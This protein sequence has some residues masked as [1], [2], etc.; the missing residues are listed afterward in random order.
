MKK[1]QKILGLPIISISDGLEVGKV[2]SIIINADRGAIDYFVVDSGIQIFSARV[3]PTE[4]VLGIGEYALTIENEG[5][6]TDISKI[7]AAIQLLQNDIKV[8]G[9]KVLT[10][11]GSLIGEIGDL[12]IDDEDSCKIKGLEF[13]ADITQKTIRLIPRDA[14]ITFGKNL[15]VVKENVE[16][17]LLD[18]VSQLSSGNDIYTFPYEEEQPIEEE[19]TVPEIEA[20][21]IPNE[22][23]QTEQEASSESSDEASILFEQRQRQYLRGRTATKSIFDN[24]GNIIIHE[25]MQIDDAIIDEAKSKGKLI[26]LVMNNKA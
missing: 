4:D 11:K 23:E 20:P 12:Y 15:T 8:K 25:G 22:E 24:E 19:Y 21:E 1:T 13:I 7:P 5:V 17:L 2:K 16:E 26:E 6:I 14:V 9:T 18:S 10:K 3:V